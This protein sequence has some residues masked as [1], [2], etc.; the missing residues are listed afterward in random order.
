MD[1]KKDKNLPILHSAEDLTVRVPKPIKQIKSAANKTQKLIKK[2][3]AY[4]P[5]GR[6]YIKRNAL[7]HMLVTDPKGARRFYNNLDEEDKL[8]NGKDEYASV[9]SV[10][11]EA[12]KRIQEPRDTLRRERLRYTE[13]CL[14]AARDAPQLEKIRE[15]EESQIRKEL[16]CVKK[17][18]L[19]AASVDAITGHPLTEPEVHHKDRMADNPRRALDPDNLEVL[20][21]DTH[22]HI[23]RQ[24]IETEEDFDE[25]R[26][27]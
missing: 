2:S 22:K 8:E 3:G 20:N 23:H 14:K 17:K 6:L 13:D 12:S 11:K 21:K 9:E 7:P 24:G 19:K 10:Q 1:D 26:R 15:I 16:P 4:T 5:D 18:K 27:S 25:Y